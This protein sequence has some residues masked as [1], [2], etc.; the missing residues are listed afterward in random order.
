MIAVMEEKVSPEW[1]P[2]LRRFMSQIK[3]WRLTEGLTQLEAARKIGVSRQAWSF[4]ERMESRPR[5]KILKELSRIT[6][7]PRSVNVEKYYGK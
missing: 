5:P 3:R 6:G 2:Q 7:I 4:Y 1:T